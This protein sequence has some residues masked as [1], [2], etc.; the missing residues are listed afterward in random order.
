MNVYQRILFTVITLIPAV[1][2]CVYIYHKDRVEKEPFGLLALLFGAGAVSFVPVYFL[3]TPINSLLLSLF[4]DKV[5]YVF[6]TPIYSSD[7]AGISYELSRSFFVTVLLEEILRWLILYIIT[8]RLEE[9]DCLFDGVVYSVVI[10]LG[11]ALAETVRFTA[12]NG[13]DMLLSQTAVAVRHILFGFIMGFFYTLWHI[14]YLAYKEEKKQISKGAYSKRKIR[15][16][17]LLLLLSLF[18][19][20]IIHALAD[21]SNKVQIEYMISWIQPVFY[22]FLILIYIICLIATMLLS[23]RDD[24]S[25]RIAVAIVKKKHPQQK[26]TE[27]DT[28]NEQ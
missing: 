1:V 2:L 4:Q 22:V 5:Q 6:G 28:A 17:V 14:Y 18:V 13:W 9:F 20:M 8:S 16:P 15:Y 12:Y 3:Q 10:S 11:F 27:E 25:K 21:F 26:F 23:K 24:E 7:F 19:P